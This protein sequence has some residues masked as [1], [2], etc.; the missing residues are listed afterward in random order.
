MRVL[1][2]SFSYLSGGVSSNVGRNV[3]FHE[4]LYE[5]T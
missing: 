1:D 4:P 5:Y 2:L 3:T